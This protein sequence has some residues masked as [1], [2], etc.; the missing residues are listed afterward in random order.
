MSAAVS[1][2]TGVRVALD[3]GTVRIGVAA[4]DPHGL[5][6]TPV[7]AVK[8]GT[9]DLDQVAALVL[10]REAVEVVVGLPTTLA[11]RAGPSVTMATDFAAELAARI[12]PVPVRFVDE[13]LT[14][15]IA[16]RTLRATGPRRSAKAGARDRASGRVDAMAAAGILQTYLDAWPRKEDS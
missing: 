3:V 7:G 8:R 10:E 11:G 4:S 6:A 14:S 15:V 16:E 1:A 9:G 5:L 13:R 2:A 12:E